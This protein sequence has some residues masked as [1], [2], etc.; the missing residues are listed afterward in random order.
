MCLLPK[1]GV[2]VLVE[3]YVPSGDIKGHVI[4][5]GEAGS[6][7]RFLSDKKY[8]PT[9]HYAY[10]YSKPLDESIK[11]F[12]IEGAVDEAVKDK[13]LD[14]SNSKGRD[15]LGVL[16]ICENLDRRGLGD[17]DYPLYWT[18]S[19]LSSQQTKKIFG[20]FKQAGPTSAQVIAGILSA[21]Y[22]IEKDPELGVIPDTD[23]IPDKYLDEIMK[24]AGP[25]LGDFVCEKLDRKAKS[26]QFSE[27]LIQ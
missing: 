1:T 21:M 4:Q 16:F 20:N 2:E 14:H 19:I 5:H 11:K 24:V 23:N 26:I 7:H 6:I 15:E 25:F 3:S 8:R 22:V 12:G 27:L 13:P 17:R 10:Q 18:G 9:V